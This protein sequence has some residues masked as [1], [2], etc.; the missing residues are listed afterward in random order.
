M[1]NVIAGNK[2]VRCLCVQV[3]QR[4]RERERESVCVCVSFYRS[5]RK[6]LLTV[7]LIYESASVSTI[8]IIERFDI[9]LKFQFYWE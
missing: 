7:L 1:V 9:G 6:S 8:L 4:E 2:H 3:F 5:L